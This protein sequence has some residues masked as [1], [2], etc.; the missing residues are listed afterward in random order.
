MVTPKLGVAS[1]L[2]FNTP[3]FGV[4]TIS[5]VLS[6]PQLTLVQIR[7]LNTWG[8]YLLYFVWKLH[9]SYHFEVTHHFTYRYIFS[10]RK[11]KPTYSSS[12]TQL[13]LATGIAISSFV[14]NPS[15][16]FQFFSS[17]WLS[18]IRCI[19]IYVVSNFSLF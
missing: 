4:T 19:L 15:F 10:K 13:T 5:E 8:G 7:H 14:H 9:C 2:R 12:A 17:V 1:I 16:F 6:N 11:D 3:S 18:I